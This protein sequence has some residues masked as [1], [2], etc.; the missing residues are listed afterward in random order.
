M[1]LIIDVGNTVIKLAVFKNNDLLHRELVEVLQ[2]ENRISSIKAEYP[3]IKRAII[4]SVAKLS[5]EDFLKIKNNFNLLVLDPTVKLPFRNLYSTPKTL[6]VDRLALVCAAV[7][8]FPS[9]N[10][11]VIDAGTCITFDFVN[12][13]NEYLGGA[14]SPGIRMRYKALHNLTA[15]LPLLETEMPDHFIGN[16]TKNAI[17]SGVVYGVLNEIDGVIKAYKEEFSDLT[18]ILTG[19]D[20]NF[21]S[22]QL[23]SSIFANSNFLLKG[24]NFILKYNSNE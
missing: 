1:N 23:K 16:S 9:K 3:K 10:V 17:N 22:K 11:L 21:L 6:G 8:E 14:I 5:D 15:N 20:S 12:S 7:S 19:G 18:V 2:L 13:N 4:S 24:L